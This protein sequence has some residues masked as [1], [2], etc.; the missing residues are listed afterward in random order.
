LCWKSG[1]N[2]SNGY[3]NNLTNR[4][5]TDT[6]KNG[7][8]ISLNVIKPFYYGTR[9]KWL[10]APSI[11]LKNGKTINLKMKAMIKQR[12]FLLLIVILFQ[13]SVLANNTA[14]KHN[15]YAINA[16][17]K[18]VYTYI[19]EKF[20][21]VQEYMI[22]TMK[23]MKIDKSSGEFALSNI[24]YGLSYHDM[25]PE[26]YIRVNGKIVLIFV[27]SSCNCD[28]EEYGISKISEDV[29]EEALDVLIGKEDN[30]VVTGQSSPIMVCRYSKNKL[31]SKLYKAGYLAPEV[32]W[33]F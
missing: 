10:K 2:L 29:K 16:M 30:F 23:I 27:D 9:S 7:I 21:D 14:K 20:V 22:V 28:L 19:Q 5:Y 32:Y 4:N 24:V 8:D 1:N 31:K 13:I 15:L 11:I 25:K 26:Y 3:F 12:N 18:A 17:S 6:D 33:F